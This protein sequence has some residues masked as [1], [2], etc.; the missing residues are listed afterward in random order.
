[1][2]RQGWCFPAYSNC[3]LGRRS[4][5][6]NPDLLERLAVYSIAKAFEH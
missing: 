3:D 4:Q 2:D 5:W 1:M 6:P